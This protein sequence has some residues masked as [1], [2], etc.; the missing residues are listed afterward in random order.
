MENKIMIKD[1]ARI[2]GK[3]EQFVRL[4][5]QQGVLPFRTAVKTSSKYSYY[6][7]PEKFYDYVGRCY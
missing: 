7:S 6:I 2:M 3:T 4:G 1:A 5:L